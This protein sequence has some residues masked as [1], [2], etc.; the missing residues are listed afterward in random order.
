MKSPTRLPLLSR[1]HL[2]PVLLVM[3]SP[4]VVGCDGGS[5]SESESGDAGG[6]PTFDADIAPILVETCV[7]E[8]CHD[9]EVTD[10]VVLEADVAY[11]NLINM[12]SKAFGIDYVKPGNID[13]SYLWLKLDNRFTE[14]GGLGNQMPIGVTLSGADKAL[15][16]EWIE[17]GAPR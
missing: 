4:L 8:A 10:T 5:E 2:L 13:E 15:I 14:V 11:D 9:A 6:S 12:P 3:A 7:F 1:L 16:E 17:S